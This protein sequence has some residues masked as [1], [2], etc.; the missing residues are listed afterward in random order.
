MI[1]Q[2]IMALVLGEALAGASTVLAQGNASTDPKAQ[3]EKQTAAPAQPLWLT[4]CSNRMQPD[5]LL[6]EFSQS[7]M[8]TKGEQRQRIATASFNRV[9]GKPQIDAAFTLPYGV[10][11]SHQVKI[12]VNDKDVASL[13]WQSCD[14][15]GCY[16][17]APVD[18]PW[19]Q[20]MRNGKELSAT[21]RSQDGRDI[22]FSFKLDGF[23][24]AEAMLP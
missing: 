10:S 24:K 2:I 20:A 8:L 6:C 16:A 11:L 9:V 17:G 23:S 4:S 15:G 14:A 22:K 18:K 21:L 13:N 19:L 1:R 7:I 3:A 5:Q 12:L